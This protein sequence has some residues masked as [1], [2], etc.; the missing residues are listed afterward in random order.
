MN[1]YDYFIRRLLLV[2]PTFL[3]ITFLCFTVIQ[4]VPGGPVEQALMRMRGG[5]A[6]GETGGDATEAAQAVSP[7]QR[8]ALRKHFGFDRPFLVRY[9]DWLFVK[10]LG[11]RME[12]Y[13]FPNK[14]AWQLIRER[15]PVSLV[16]GLTGFLL[17]YMVCIPL[18]MAKA[19][20]H[21]TAFD[22]VSSV[23]VFIGYAMP[24]FAFGM[25]LKMLFCGTVEGMWN[26]LPS[27]GFHSQDFA[28]MGGWAKFVD[29]VRHMFLPVLCYM[30]G[31]FAVLTL[32]MKNSLLEQIN[33][34]YVRTVVAKGAGTLRVLV[35]H[36][37]RNA[38]IPIATGFG[39]VLTLMFAGSVIIERVFE[40][41]GMG[42]L[43]ME[44]IVG[45]DYPVFMGVLSLTSILG[46][47][48]NV[49][50]DFC[51]VMIDPRITF[52]RN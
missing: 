42:S 36:V 25:L 1:R 45:R 12:S 7:E 13:K 11:M 50:S 24:A 31:S 32:L 17:T 19:L 30:I 3:G 38:L 21:G 29:L 27:T 23:I 10:R 41:P 20:K 16:F 8:E 5:G 6:G 51:Y 37:L 43:S 33:S 40:I 4:F 47:L 46:L 39:G 9:A 52:D 14:T 22:L 35:C 15:F 49:L 48:G 34:D 18:G 2:F 28:V 44:A 26:I